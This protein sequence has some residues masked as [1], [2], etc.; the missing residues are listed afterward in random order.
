MWLEI[1][2]HRRVRWMDITITHRVPKRIETLFQD[3]MI[4][5]QGWSV[6]DFMNEVG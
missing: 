4:L 3:H 6:V 5:V 2:F 1:F